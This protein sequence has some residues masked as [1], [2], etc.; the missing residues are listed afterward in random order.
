MAAQLTKRPGDCFVATM[1]FIQLS[2]ED[3]RLVCDQLGRQMQRLE[4]ELVHTD[5]RDMQRGLA[6][7]VARLRAVIDQI[8][9]V[10]PMPDLEL[11]RNAEM[12]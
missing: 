2:Q 11:V 5:S 8:E 4:S 12:R 7:D 9:R 10:I 6:G 3:A 1:I